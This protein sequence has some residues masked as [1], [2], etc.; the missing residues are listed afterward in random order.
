MAP[1]QRM[2]KLLTGIVMAAVIAGCAA[3]PQQRS[4]GDYL[5]DKA[6]A[7]KV[8]ATIVQEPELKATQINVETYNGVVQLSG[9]VDSEN[10]IRRAGEV[11]NGV[12]GVKS[13]INN[14][15]VRPVR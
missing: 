3:G 5:D 15:V 12:T 8:K 7:A 2:L 6:I 9:F 14:I 4:T 13:V 11:A 10:D 1:L